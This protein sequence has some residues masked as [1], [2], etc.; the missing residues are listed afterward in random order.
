MTPFDRSVRPHSDI[1]DCRVTRGVIAVTVSF[2]SISLCLGMLS[3]DRREPAQSVGTG[4]EPAARGAAAEEGAQGASPGAAARPAEGAPSKTSPT[5]AAAGD[6]Y[7]GKVTET[8]DA[9]GYTYVKVEVGDGATK[10]AAGPKTA[11]EKGQT[12]VVSSLTPMRDFES[13]SLGRTF[14]E[15]DFAASLRVVG[16]TPAGAGKAAGA[17]AGSGAGGS[18]T[19]E[20]VETMDAGGYTYVKLETDTGTRWAAGPQTPITVGERVKLSQIMPMRNFE[21]PTLGRKFA[22]IDFVPALKVVSDSGSADDAKTGERPARKIEPVPAL[23]GPDAHT[24][25]EIVSQRNELAGKEVAVRGRVVKFN[26]NILDRNWIHIQDGTGDPDA[27]THDLTVTSPDASAEPGEI[28]VVRGK[29]A[30]DR[31]FGAGYAYAVML[32]GATVQS[33]DGGAAAPETPSK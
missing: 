5:A 12:V 32:E 11:V 13:P 15:I 25:G 16:D 2:L 3:C 17:A 27:G 30:V 8:M 31:D 6:G 23:E 18:Y 1:R 33:E 26:P 28:V 22:E 20:V 7:R 9:G 21:S 14:E 10:W 4:T 24:I 29:V 19:G